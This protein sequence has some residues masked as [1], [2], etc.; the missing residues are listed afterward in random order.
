M[1]EAE[2][3]ILALELKAHL[4]R[5]A[6]KFITISS[7]IQQSGIKQSEGFQVIYILL[8]SYVSLCLPTYY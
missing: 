5:W 6:G 1:G 8:H 7:R 4:S 3:I 2:A